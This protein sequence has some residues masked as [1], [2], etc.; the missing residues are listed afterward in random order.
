MF[1]RIETERLDAPTGSEVSGETEWLDAQTGSEASGETEW[2]DTQSEIGSDTSGEDEWF[3]AE[4]GLGSEE[5]EQ[6]GTIPGSD[7][8]LD[9]LLPAPGSDVPLDAPVSVPFNH[10]L[11]E[12]ELMADM[13]PRT[14][15][16]LHRISNQGS[17]TL[18]HAQ[19]LEAIGWELPAAGISTMAELEVP[20]NAA[21][22]G[23]GIVASIASMGPALCGENTAC[24]EMGETARSV[25]VMEALNFDPATFQSGT[26]AVAART[27]GSTVESLESAKKFQDMGTQTENAAN[28]MEKGVESL[29]SNEALEQWAQTVRYP[30][31]NRCVANTGTDETRLG[32]NKAR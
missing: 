16:I 10:P 19:E 27:V 15:E 3:D 21:M 31:F 2:F 4:T 30:F 13:Y 17:V 12:S 25:G 23:K 26:A 5:P 18:E 9:V 7:A 22:K 8:P 28:T 32:Q 29:I 20:V 1:F 24:L 11:P 14:M 6:H